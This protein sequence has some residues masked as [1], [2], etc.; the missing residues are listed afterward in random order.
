MNRIHIAY[1][2]LAAGLIF[3]SCK[4]E[5]DSVQPLTY[6]SQAG[7]LSTLGGIIETTNGNYYNLS[8]TDGG[9]FGVPY[10][11]V[12]HNISEFRGN[13]VTA[14]L[15]LTSLQQRD[16][17][18]YTNSGIASTGYGEYMWKDSYYLIAGVNTTLEGIESF[19]ASQLSSLTSAQ[20]NQ[21]LHAEGEN[22]FLRALA[23]FNLVRVFGMPYYNAPQTNL[24][25][26]VKLTS[27]LTD[28]PGRST[29]DST[30]R[31]I[32]SDLQQAAI[33]MNGTGQQ[34]HTFAN[35]ESAWALLSRVYL[36]MGGTYNTPSS[37]YNQLA[38]TYADSVISSGN[39]SLLQSQEY[40]NLFAADESGSLGRASVGANPEVIFAQDNSQGGDQINSFYHYL[41]Y[42]GSLTGGFY[43]SN[44]FIA[45]LGSGDLRA[46]FLQVNVLGKT[47]STKYD[48]EPNYVY[49]DAPTIYLR[50]GEVYLN[51][52]EAEVKGGD[53]ADALADL[54]VIHTRAGLS[55]LTG[56]SGQDL[57]TAILNERRIELAFEGQN[58]FDYFRNGLAMTRPAG[59]TG[60]SAFTIQAN[61]PTVV[62]QI[63]FDEI[64]TNPKLV[65][66]PQ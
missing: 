34:A 32:I 65:Q 49:S 41:N 7:E 52:A 59:D 60:G 63:P 1:S 50:L 5:L 17:Y 38:V 48:V 20:Q 8:N 58:G 21:L 9:V 15:T 28:I 29:V 53:N 66:N 39:F 24:G 26:M 6:I 4:K 16:A 37:T 35:V 51:R 14:D 55:A 3:S 25:V 19:K 56:I 36:Y 57:F 64:N 43:P 2:I 27:S 46:Q 13:N 22:Y 47:E 45:L 40:V 18:D 30:Y 62:M 61:D 42:Y 10:S 44:S 11:A 31:Q 23:L 54:N 33:D 12:L